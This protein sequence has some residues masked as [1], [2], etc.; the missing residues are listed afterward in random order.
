MPIMFFLFFLAHSDVSC[1]KLLSCLLIVNVTFSLA[2]GWSRM[3][4]P[5]LPAQIV[6]FVTEYLDARRSWNAAERACTGD[7]YSIDPY[8]MTPY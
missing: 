1:S 7:S 8:S 2:A 4:S 6:V 3:K 5:I